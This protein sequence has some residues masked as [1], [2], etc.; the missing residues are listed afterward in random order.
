MFERRN[1]GLAFSLTAGVG[2]YRPNL[3]DGLTIPLKGSRVVRMPSGTPVERCPV[4]KKLMIL[5]APPE[6][7]STQT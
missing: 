7:P 2:S 3:S 6:G 1:A 4:G 5:G